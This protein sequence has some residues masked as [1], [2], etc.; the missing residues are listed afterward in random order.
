MGNQA[1]VAD[2]VREATRYVLEEYSLWIASAGVIFLYDG[3]R[4]WTPDEVDHKFGTDLYREAKS[5]ILQA[6]RQHPAAVQ[7]EDVPVHIPAPNGTLLQQ[8]PTVNHTWHWQVPG[9]P[10]EF[11][12]NEL[13]GVRVRIARA[14]SRSWHMAMNNDTRLSRFVGVVSDP[15]KT[16]PRFREGAAKLE[17]V[18]VCPPGQT[19][20][21]V[22]LWETE[23]GGL[24]L[25]GFVVRNPLQGEVTFDTL[26]R[27][28]PAP[29]IVATDNKGRHRVFKR[30]SVA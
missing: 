15:A 24:N 16:L 23:G 4:V 29:Y 26:G 30:P 27:N 25:T 3:H 11:F 13:S 18:V 28:V 1:E 20:T 8:R 22:T 2:D 7:L 10:D 21:T 5:E 17:L 14:L 6:L 9:Q 12:C 19:H